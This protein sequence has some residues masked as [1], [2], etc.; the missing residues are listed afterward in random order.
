MRY[1]IRGGI[2]IRAE[3]AAKP[4]S[5]KSK[6]LSQLIRGL[7]KVSSSF[8]YGCGK[9]RYYDDI[10]SVS[11]FVA[12]VDSEQQLSRTQIVAGKKTTIRK[13]VRH[14]NRLSVLNVHEF[15]KGASQY[16]RGF[17]VNVLSVIPIASIRSR[18]LRIIL[19]ALKPGGTC[20][21]VVQYRNSDFTRM[22]KLPNATQ[23]LD[24]FLM[25][26]YRGYSFYGLIRPEALEQ[27]VIAAGF[28]VVSTKLNEG[29]VYLMGMKPFP[30]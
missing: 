20:L 27:L 10:L 8:D 6:Y 14:S 2:V 29:S 28:E 9:L 19:S 16:D 1:K 17:C 18:V 26:S 11:H 4:V 23:W 3:N 24:G 12:L 15:S 5:Q 25:N 22:R 7:D 21:F 13:R 30:S